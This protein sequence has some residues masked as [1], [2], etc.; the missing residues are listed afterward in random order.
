MQTQMSHLLTSFSSG[1]DP[2]S[3]F[4]QRSFHGVKECFEVDNWCLKKNLHTVEWACAILSYQSDFSGTIWHLESDIFTYITSI[5]DLSRWTAKVDYTLTSTIAL[6]FKH[7]NWI[8]KKMSPIST[9]STMLQINDNASINAWTLRL[10]ASTE[11]LTIRHK[12]LES[13]L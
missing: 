6:L 9:R 8:S 5:T 10:I 11:P 4:A 1:D 13:I 12:R 2:L 3:F 7:K